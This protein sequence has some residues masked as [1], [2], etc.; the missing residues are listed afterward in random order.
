MFCCEAIYKSFLYINIIVNSI[1]DFK[2]VFKYRNYK[3]SIKNR[4][5]MAVKKE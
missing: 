4:A 5:K 1:V 3:I 2:A